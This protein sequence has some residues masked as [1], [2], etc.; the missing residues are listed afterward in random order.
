MAEKQKVKYIRELTE[1]WI[2]YV[3]SVID[4][5]Y[6]G[7]GMS[8]GLTEQEAYQQVATEEGPNHQSARDILSRV[9]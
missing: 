5:I 1:Y 8:L 6:V 9:S 3:N 2:E 7:V 4:E